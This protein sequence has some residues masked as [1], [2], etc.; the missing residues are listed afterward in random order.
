MILDE[1]VAHKRAEIQELMA[2]VPLAE[3]RTRAEAAPEARDFAGALR[4]ENVAL[5]AEIKLASPSRGEIRAEV[6]PTQVA[7]IYAENGAAAISVLTD[8]KFFR[9]D[10]NNL[11]A[12]RL[13]TDVPL[14]RKDF[15]VD[16][17]QVYESR[18]LQ[19]DAILLIVRILD[20]AQLRDYRALAESLGISALVEVH[21]EGELERALSSGARIL[22]INNRNLA[23]FSTDLATTERLAPLIPDDKILVSESGIF[24]QTEV[25]RAARVNADAV[26]VG[27]ALMR[28]ED[29]G[30][31]VREL[32]Q[33]PK[34][35]VQG[36]RSKVQK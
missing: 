16:A 30:A 11:K 19:A 2:R 34:C 28:A 17:Y 8:R 26:L 31:K 10:P 21:D 35:R 5:I 6:N 33:V 7:R 25:E 32:A 12:A 9:G 20:D 15:I 23:D 29:V 27:E 24:A 4:G 1:I 22:G 18:A 3:L 13:G 14:L 36:A